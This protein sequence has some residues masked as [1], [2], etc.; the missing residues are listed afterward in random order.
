MA[1]AKKDPWEKLDEVTFE[2]K[3]AKRKNLEAAVMELVDVV[4][5]YLTY[6]AFEI[7]KGESS[8]SNFEMPKGWPDDWAKTT[9]PEIAFIEKRIERRIELLRQAA[10]ED[11]RAKSALNQLSDDIEMFKH[12]HQR[13]RYFLGILMGAKLMGASKKRLQEIAWPWTRG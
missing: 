2:F 11:P 8:M 1:K 5:G 7:F 4:H 9:D 13:Q 12:S 10:G 3:M 6:A